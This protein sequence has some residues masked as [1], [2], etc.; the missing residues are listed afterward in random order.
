MVMFIGI[1]AI[2]CNCLQLSANT[3]NTHVQHILKDSWNVQP[4]Q[5]QVDEIQMDQLIAGWLKAEREQYAKTEKKN[6][7]EIHF[8]LIAVIVL[9][10]FLGVVSYDFQGRKKKHKAI[11]K[12][13]SMKTD[14]CINL[15]NE[16]KTPVNIILGLIDILKKNIEKE[17]KSRALINL[18]ILSRESE[19]LLFH[20]DEI[21]SALAVRYSPKPTEQIHDDMVVYA[22]YLY[23]CMR[24]YAET[25]K[26]DFIFLSDIYTLMMDYSPDYIRIV[27]NN[28]LSNA[29]KRCKPNDKVVFF[30]GYNE[31][32]EKCILNISDTGECISD[33]DLP[34][35]FSAFLPDQLDKSDNKGYNLELFFT[36]QLI[37]KL[38]G[39]IE[40]KSNPQEGTV[41]TI[42]L[43]VTH[44]YAFEKKVHL[45]S[46]ISSFL[47]NTV[48]VRNN[49]IA[50]QNEA[51]HVTVESLL[52][53][54]KTKKPLV[55]IVG[56]NKNR[57]RYLASVLQSRYGIWVA[58]N[59]KEALQIIE[60]KMPD[61][62]IS[63]ALT[64]LMNGFKLC[65]KI[66]ESDSINAIPIILIA[67]KLTVDDRVYGF[68]CGVDAFLSHPF[69][70]EELF[71]VIQ[72]LLNNRKLI[73]ENCT[74]IMASSDNNTTQGIKNRKDIDFLERVTN[75]IY[76]ESG[77]TGDIISL[78]ASEMCLSQ[79]QLNRRI[80]AATGLTTSNYVLKVRLNKAKK[81]LIKSQKPIGEIAMDCGFNDFAYFSR[82]FK[83]EFG[84]TPTSFQRLPNCE[85]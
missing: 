44:Q 73:R 40:V 41:F 24:G 70:D 28:L 32:A 56:D 58:E 42:I 13:E 1:G 79:S 36:K 78:L 45:Q 11:L 4:K 22:N 61:L 72:Q 84:M 17:D 3:A 47:Q 19:N 54:G 34:Y 76:R 77:K 52:E 53:N 7:H 49:T 39:R 10:I 55:L 63:E 27:V 8:L 83:K 68:K 66:K 33:K 15:S 43:P 6:Q 60:E 50:A 85:N 74:Q 62:I 35:L 14:Y 2:L 64:S 23:E 75:I 29:F 82:S 30:L 9:L 67:S 59:E 26:I 31:S 21:L 57:I 12:L 81:L 16:F 18:D 80:K 48:S 5:N 25:K 20:I 37:E 65:K 71:A 46:D 38:N 69:S 51:T